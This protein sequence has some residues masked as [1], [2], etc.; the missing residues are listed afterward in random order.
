MRT[1]SASGLSGL[2]L[3]SAE[4]HAEQNSY[5]N[6]SSGTKARTSSSPLRM[7]SEPGT[8]RA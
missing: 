2:R 4:P 8:I 1:L 6:P 3:H 5:G 7:R